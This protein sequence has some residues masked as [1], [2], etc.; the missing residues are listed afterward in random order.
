MNIKARPKENP[1]GQPEDARSIH[2]ISTRNADT[3]RRGFL[4]GSVAS[5]AATQLL[6]P[7]VAHASPSAA[8]S[9]PAASRGLG[10]TTFDSLGAMRRVQA[11][12]LHV[13]YYELGPAT[14]PTVLLLHGFPYDIHSFIDVA[15]MLASRGA[16]VIVPYLRGHGATT[17]VDAT[18]PRAGQQGAIGD[19][20]IQLMNALRID[21]AVL[22]GYD[23]GGRAACV[24]A[25]L[26]PERCAGLVS[27]NSYLIQDIAGAGSPIGPM[28]ESGLWYQYYFQT[29]RGRKGL[30]ANRGEVARVIWTRNSPNW[31]FD[32]TTLARSVKAFD[33]A[34]YV[35]IVLHSYRH[36]LGLAPGVPAYEA[37]ERRL[38]AL[39]AITVPAITLDGDADGVV[40][41]TDGRSSARKFTGPRDHRV[42]PRV[43]HNLPQEAPEAFA[44]AVLGLI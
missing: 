37:I 25:A 1:N 27:V 34:D 19:D 22:A 42:I 36:R 29:E 18:T 44:K 32:E 16:R 31:H 3:G 5:L 30:T 33:N 21:R 8:T 43:G 14:G 6:L 38:A 35:E 13:A 17:F 4:L 20:V 2:K 7:G 41:A 24:A 12:P 10:A 40:P 9:S 26:W 28:I 11:G 23:W 39:P 15:P